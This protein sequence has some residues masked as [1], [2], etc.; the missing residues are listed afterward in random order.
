MNSDLFVMKQEKPHRLSTM[1]L[2]IC[3]P[4]FFC[5]NSK[6]YWLRLNF[7]AEELRGVVL[8]FLRATFQ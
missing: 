5:E 7:K 4:N 8:R 3:Y 6:R 1:R 2:R